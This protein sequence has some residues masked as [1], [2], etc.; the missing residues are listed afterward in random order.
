MIYLLGDIVKLKKGHPC[1]TNEWKILRTGVEFK[2]EC[3]G[4]KRQVWLK[5]ED[6]NKGV[7]K[8]KNSDGK[9]V[10]VTNFERE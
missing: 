3:E 2:L 5:R 9:F 7:R 1:G 10:S 6:F 4:C 8:I